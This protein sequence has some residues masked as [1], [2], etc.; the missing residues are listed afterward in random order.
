M[1][2]LLAAGLLG[3]LATSPAIGFAQSGRTPASQNPAELS[4]ERQELRE[5]LEKLRRDIAARED[6]REEARDAL[7]D[8]EQAISAANRRLRELGEQQAALR[9]RLAE[10]DRQVRT[11]EAAI[12][13]RQEELARLLRQNYASGNLSP[14]RALLSGDDPHR[15]GRD[16]AYLGYVSR[17]RTALI[18]ELEQE[19]ASLALLQTETREQQAKLSDVLAQEQSTRRELEQQRAAREAVLQSI[20]R[21]LQA[22]Q[23]R[24]ATLARDEQRLGRLIE[25][26]N[27]VIAQRQ[28]EQRRREQRER[29]QQAA[30][31]D[32]GTTL[33]PATTPR[34][35]ITG[36]NTE[37][38]DSATGGDFARLKGQ[39]RLPVRG[40]VIGRFGANRAGGGTWKGIFIQADNGSEVRAVADGKVVFS[41]W[42]RGFGNLLIIDHGNQYLS[43]YGNNESL[44][45]QAGDVVRGGDTVA[46]V[47]AT[48][49]QPESGLYFELRHRGQPLDPLGWARL[50]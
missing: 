5:Q 31:R 26:L 20:S 24:A 30:R 25:E 18:R 43:I 23:R 35:R 37:V 41:E 12:E 49:G 4:R 39:L 1:A 10:L 14:W 13:T 9:R 32:G 29:E 7:R 6:D 38:P 27:R 40:D 34:D 28:A 21:D 15:L 47:G 50:R 11:Q 48:G 3:L 33:P 2:R 42:L 8:S 22:Q 16:L 45:K 19:L 46:Q 17:A 44:L 36:R